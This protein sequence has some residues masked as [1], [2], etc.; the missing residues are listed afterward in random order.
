MVKEK[1]LADFYGKLEDKLGS[2]KAG[3]IED[4]FIKEVGEPFNIQIDFR[5]IISEYGENSVEY[6]ALIEACKA[7]PG[8]LEYYGINI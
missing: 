5:G 1:Q 7:I 6:S 3:Q 4:K 8:I 2:E